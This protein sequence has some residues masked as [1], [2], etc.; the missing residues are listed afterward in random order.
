[1]KTLRSITVVTLMDKVNSAEVRS[2]R[3]QNV[4]KSVRKIKNG[5]CKW[6]K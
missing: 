2:Y 6:N 3:I 4:L 1:M 5:T